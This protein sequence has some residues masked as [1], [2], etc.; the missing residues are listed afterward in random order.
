MILKAEKLIYFAISSADLRKST[1]IGRGFP[2]KSSLR[3]QATSS[4]PNP[5]PRDPRKKSPNLSTSESN[6]ELFPLTTNHH[7]NPKPSPTMAAE[8]KERSGLAVG[9]N[10]GH[11]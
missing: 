2:P 1:G 3:R 10:K 7:D 4:S 8:R 5:T 6:L 9:L 11:V